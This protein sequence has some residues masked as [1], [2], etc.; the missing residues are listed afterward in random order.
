M[1][2][3]KC[4]SLLRRV[5]STQCLNKI[6]L[7]IHEV[8]VDAVVHQVVL[9]GLNVLRC[10]EVDA[11]LLAEVLNL[12]VCTSQ[13]NKLVVE[14]AEVFLERLWCITSR[15]AGNEDGEKCAGGLLFHNVQHGRHLIELFGAD[16]GASGKAKIDLVRISPLLSIDV[17]GLALVRTR[18]CLPFIISFVKGFPS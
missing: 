18:E 15:V 10:A 9:S 13:A 5:L 12:I 4:S 6:T 3:D 2:Q 14:L 16:I 8:E 1:V 17:F 11:V 7:R